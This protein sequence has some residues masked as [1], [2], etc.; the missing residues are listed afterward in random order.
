VKIRIILLK[1]GSSE[2]IHFHRKHS[3]SVGK[4]D[5]PGNAG[6][7]GKSGQ[8]GAIFGSKLSF[9]LSC[10]IPIYQLFAPYFIPSW[11]IFTISSSLRESILWPLLHSW[12]WKWFIIIIE[13]IILTKIRNVYRPGL[14]RFVIWAMLAKF[15]SFY[16]VCLCRRLGLFYWIKLGDSPT[17]LH[18]VGL[19]HSAA[20][21]A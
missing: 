2:N 12:T 7:T 6:F 1:S 18:W 15:D 11:H 3:F 16:S 4:T 8:T 17:Y 14:A 5:Q 13:S 9:L 21:C 10:C 19:G 20:D